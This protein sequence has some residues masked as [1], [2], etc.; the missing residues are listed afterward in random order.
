MHAA[1]LA[2]QALAAEVLDLQ[3]TKALKPGSQR[4]FELQAKGCGLSMLRGMISAGAHS[5][6]EAAELYRKRIPVK[7]FEGEPEDAGGTGSI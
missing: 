2:E 6:P 3:T 7:G 1:E 5:S 4:W